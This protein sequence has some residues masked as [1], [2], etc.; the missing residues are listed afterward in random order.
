MVKPLT[1]KV[2]DN[3]ILSISTLIKEHLPLGIS[4]HLDRISSC[5]TPLDSEEYLISSSAS[6]SRKMEFIAGRNS[7]SKSL[8]EIYEGKFIIGR[9]ES[10]APELPKNVVGSL[11]H[12]FPL[13][14]SICAKESDYKALGIDIEKHSSWNPGVT[15][16]F[17]TKQ[18]LALN[19]GLD[20]KTDIL[21]TILFSAKESSFKA[22]SFKSKPTLPSL[23]D[24]S[25]N[26]EQTTDH[27]FK[28]T[29]TWCDVVLNGIV[30][31]YASWVAC[32]TFS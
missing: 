16:T 1:T 4:F 28:A 2:N 11:T 6:P 18:D 21:C 32:I 7:L 22:I 9:Q 17:I 3:D 29:I 30:V 24:I 5:Q 25:V 8:K 31:I 27:A 13:V 12:K 20:I 14:A 19:A 23:L 26:L 10:G 15:P